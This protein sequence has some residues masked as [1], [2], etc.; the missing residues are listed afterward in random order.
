MFLLLFPILF[1]RFLYH[2][3][4]TVP[5]SFNVSVIVPIFQRIEHVKIDENTEK[6]KTDSHL[7]LYRCK[8]LQGITKNN[9][10][11]LLINLFI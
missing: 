11:I 8:R 2:I 7:I 9:L 10:H 1:A 6:S 3:P 5:S 4:A